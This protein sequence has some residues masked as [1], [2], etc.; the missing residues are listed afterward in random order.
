MLSKERFSRG[1]SN[2]RSKIGLC[3]LIVSAIALLV[4]AVVFCFRFFGGAEEE[5][6]RERILPPIAI[7][8]NLIQINEYSR[9]GTPLRKVKGIV[10]H[11]TANPGTDAIANRNYFNN[12]PRLNQKTGNKTYASSHFV[13]GLKGDIIQCVPLEEIAY[14]SNDRNKD[15]ISIECCHKRKD[16]KFTRK[17]YQS[18]VNLVTYLCVKYD[19][20]SEDIIRHYDVTGKNCPR[21][22]VE[23][24][25]AWAG[26]RVDVNVALAKC[27]VR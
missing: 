13:I 2:S 15:T 20:Q 16:G 3:A 18:L 17:T 23:N 12:L 26:F 25:K 24:P 19:L 6:H 9:P 5:V 10:V 7:T 4:V 11:Y 21:Y 14:A 1:K 27:E 22:F 8:E